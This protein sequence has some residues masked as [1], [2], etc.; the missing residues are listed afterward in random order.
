MNIAYKKYNSLMK[1]MD[2][3]VD[4]RE[5]LKT[6]LLENTKSSEVLGYL[7]N[8]IYRVSCLG[9]LDTLDFVEEF[10]RCAYHQVIVGKKAPEELVENGYLK[11]D[12]YQISYRDVYYNDNPGFDVAWRYSLE[13]EINIEGVVVSVRRVAVEDKV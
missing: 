1:S 3:V 4:K 6:Y 7:K 2:T 13:V 11:G 9:G 12:I 10:I 8:Y 5:D